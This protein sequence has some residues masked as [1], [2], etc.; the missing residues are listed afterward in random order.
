MALSVAILPWLNCALFVFFACRPSGESD[1]ILL[2]RLCNLARSPLVSLLYLL[3]IV[4]EPVD[5]LST[6]QTLSSLWCQS[7]MPQDTH[8]Q[9]ST[10]Q[11]FFHI[12]RWVLLL[13]LS[14]ESMLSLTVFLSQC[15]SFQEIAIIKIIISF[16]SPL[17][18]DC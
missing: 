15:S 2:A 13:C 3:T 8:T 12:C 7:F 18:H 16:S 6:L 9:L 1:A 4:A 5:H 11:Y 10:R 17:M 14:V